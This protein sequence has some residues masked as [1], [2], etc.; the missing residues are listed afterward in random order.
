MNAN[1]AKKRKPSKQPV[2]SSFPDFP[3]PFVV[4]PIDQSLRF[5]QVSDQRRSGNPL[6][7]NGSD[8]QTAPRHRKWNER[9]A[10]LE[11]LEKV[12]QRKSMQQSLESVMEILGET[13]K[14][15][16]TRR[17]EDEERRLK[18][19]ADKKRMRKQAIQ[20]RSSIKNKIIEEEEENAEEKDGC[21][22]IHGKEGVGKVDGGDPKAVG[23]F[24]SENTIENGSAMNKAVKANTQHTSS[25]VNKNVA[26]S[27]G[28][29]RVYAERASKDLD[30]ILEAKNELM[31]KRRQSSS[32]ITQN[33]PILKISKNIQTEDHESEKSKK[34][35]EL[36]N[37][38]ETQAFNIGVKN[39]EIEQKD[40]TITQLSTRVLRLENELLV[41]EN[42]RKMLINQ[43]MQAKG[44]VRIF[45]RVKPRPNRPDTIMDGR[46][47]PQETRKIARIKTARPA[48]KQKE[49]TMPPII[50]ENSIIEVAD[51]GA[52]PR[53][54]TVLD[55]ESAKRKNYFFDRVFTDSASQED[56][57]NE[58]E[59]YVTMAYDG[60]KVVI[61]AYGQTG[62]G[63]TYT[64]QGT[65][66]SK[67]I[68]P[69]ALD[70]LVDMKA[71]S[72]KVTG[73]VRISMSVLEIYNEKLIDLL[74]P[75]KESINIHLKNNTVK[76]ANLS[77]VDI[78]HAEQLN[79]V[80]NT[81]SGNRNIEKTVFNDESSRSHCVYR[82]KVAKFDLDGKKVKGFLNIIDL[83][84]CERFS[85]DI[86]DTYKMKKIQTEA[87]FINKSL[88]TLGRILRI[89]K[90]NRA[91]NTNKN[92][93]I[94]ETKLT[95]ALQ[96]NL[97]DEQAITLMILNVCQMEKN[98][99]QTRETLNFS[100]IN[101]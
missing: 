37:D 48:K 6:Q 46:P 101:S 16:G 36:L 71:N 32:S 9:G 68:L 47:I 13:E 61:F 39:L 4:K 22:E 65:G 73:R 3:D 53:M 42:K 54:L 64:L 79:A 75:K 21:D 51:Q 85:D 30:A 84:G 5:K 57:F 44:N 43:I 50:S 90:E 20:G 78:E 98:F 91:N 18:E 2:D 63:K 69:R 62:S 72:E 82:I 15:K 12:A 100:T 93:P 88:T 60:G 8:S 26:S 34:I 67:G 23:T 96:D 94:R 14:G 56:I 70:M 89:K 31:Q 19:E 92:L 52:E 55:P 1:R 97:E 95:R 25:Q 80:I 74:D 77:K 86:D 7:I 87:T 11:P 40:E 83:A 81:A 17:R 33:P 10:S 41:N 24:D 76:L 58:F 28:I 66:D 59:N 29:Q 49:A 99:C 45:C 38:T 27:T 35:A